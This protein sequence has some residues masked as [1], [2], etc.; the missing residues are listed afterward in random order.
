M[1]TIDIN[2]ILGQPGTH[3]GGVLTA[4]E[5]LDEMDRQEIASGWI[6]HLAGAT[7][8]VET[9]NRLL[10]EQIRNAGSGRSRLTP[11]P[12]ADWNV[13]DGALDWETWAELGCRGIRLCPSFY[14][15]A[16]DP[17]TLDALLARLAERGWFLQVP[18]RP[19]CGATQQTGKIADAVA[20]AARRTDLPMVVV[21]PKRQEFVELCAAL[22]SAGSLHVDVGNL[23][24]GTAIRDL[25]AKG[26]ADRLVSG[27]G[28]GVCCSAPARDIV[29]YSPIPESARE[30]ILHDNPMR[31]VGRGSNGQANL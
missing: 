12:V 1:N 23:S 9:G 27:S 2:L 31:L 7:Q 21:C 3:P 4:R 13:P 20:L 8:S 28:F 15:P 16:E 18:V 22:R 24:T 14:G 26:Y 17:A 30:A 6:T 29:L 5:L 25:V 10:L 11:V 19:F